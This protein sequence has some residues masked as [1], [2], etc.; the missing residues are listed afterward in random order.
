MTLILFIA[1]LCGVL[2][3]RTAGKHSRVKLNQMKTLAPSLLHLGILNKDKSMML[4]LNLTFYS[5][6]PSETELDGDKI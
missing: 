1:N 6:L 2:T 5:G 3:G 4:M